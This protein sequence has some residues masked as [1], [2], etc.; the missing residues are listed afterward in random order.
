MRFYILSL[1]VLLSYHTV[2]QSSPE[3]WRPAQLMPTKTLA[4]RIQKEELGKTIIMSVGPDA[5]IKGS[6]DIGPGRE[7]QN[8][9]KLKNH[10][11]SISKEQEVVIYCGCCPFS[12]CPNIRPAFSALVEM[13]FKNAKLLDIPKNIKVDWLDKNYPTQAQP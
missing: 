6:V 2:A 3:P 8:I 11:R 13:G 9:A 1:L 10:L 4:E 7:Y 12:K 5:I